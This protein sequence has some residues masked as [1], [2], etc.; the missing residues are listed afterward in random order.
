MILKGE[1]PSPLK[2]PSGC[3]FHERCPRALDICSEQRPEWREVAP[4][5]F[6]ACHLHP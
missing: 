1:L 2:P 3:A 5:H 6:V 4:E